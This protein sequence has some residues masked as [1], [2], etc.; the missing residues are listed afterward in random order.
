M[1]GTLAFVSPVVAAVLTGCAALAPY[2]TYPRM[3]GPG[4]EATA[5]RVAICYDGLASSP[6]EVHIA[7]QQECPPD[8]TATYFDTDWRL[9]YC[10]LLLPA[11]AT[12]VC[13]ARK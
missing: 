4:E 9:Q 10:P 11:R 8:T 3:A 7:A 2:P 12:F 1:S 13:A 5:Q 6:E